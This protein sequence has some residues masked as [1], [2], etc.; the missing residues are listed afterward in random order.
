MPIALLCQGQCAT[1]EDVQYAEMQDVNT[2]PGHYLRN[3]S[4]LDIGV[5]G[6]IG[7]VQH[8]EHSPKFCSFLLGHPVYCLQLQHV[9]IPKCHHQGA[10][11]SYAKAV[12]LAYEQLPDDDTQVSKHVGVIRNKQALTQTVCICSSSTIKKIQ[13]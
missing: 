7:I 6:Y 12:T 3:R 9:S 1:A 11:C 4:T 13:A 2:F 5:L 10:S 8:K